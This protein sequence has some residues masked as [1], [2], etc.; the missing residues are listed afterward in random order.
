LHATT[1]SQQQALQTF[2]W[3][4]LCCLPQ[5]A[6]LTLLLLVL[7]FPARGQ[8]IADASISGNNEAIMLANNHSSTPAASHTIDAE[9]GSPVPVMS[10]PSTDDK[11]V[12]GRLFQNCNAVL[13]LQFLLASEEHSPCAQLKGEKE[14]HANDTD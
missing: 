6:F 11:K 4:T 3:L 7:L 5:A 10:S 14:Q 12:K 1:S 2:K 9:N 8:E 13:Q